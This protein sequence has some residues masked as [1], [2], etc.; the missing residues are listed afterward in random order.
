MPA[1]ATILTGLL[2]AGV[3]TAAGLAVLF[4]FSRED[5]DDFGS[6][7]PRGLRTHRASFWGQRLRP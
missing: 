1:L 3:W 2:I 6:L 7:R 5:C 4:R